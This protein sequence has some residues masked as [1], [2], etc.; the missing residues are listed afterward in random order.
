MA[1]AV[2]SGDHHALMG[3]HCRRQQKRTEA[4]SGEV[5]GIWGF[6]LPIYFQDHS[7]FAQN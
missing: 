4:N 1:E 7:W 3:K 6:Q 5:A 2:D